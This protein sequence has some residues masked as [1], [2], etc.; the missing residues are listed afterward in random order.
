[1]KKYLFFL[2][3]AIYDHDYVQAGVVEDAKQEIAQ[4]QPISISINS[5]QINKIKF[6]PL[7]LIA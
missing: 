1:M 3:L 2:L 7:N 4:Q 5:Q 6:I